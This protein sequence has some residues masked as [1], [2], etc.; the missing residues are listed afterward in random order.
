M[1]VISYNINGIRAAL[2]KGLDQWIQ[3][4]SPDILCL[5]EIKANESQF[6]IRIF[7]NLGY[8]SY[9][10][11]AQKAGYSGTAILS[12]KPPNRITCGMDHVQYDAEG[13]VLKADFDGF[14]IINVYM[15][16]GSSGDVRQTFKYQFLDDFYN[17]IAQ[18]LKIQPN[19]IVC[20]DYNICHKPI[21]IHNPQQN[22]HTSGF[23]PEE[24]QWLTKFLELGFVDT[25][26]FFCQEPHHYS[27]W[28]YRANARAKNLGWRIDYLL[29]STPLS[30]RLV[31]AQILPHAKHSD[32]CPVVVS[33]DV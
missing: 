23:L 19:L 9:W 27:W 15:P 18:Q 22:K 2:R 26:R 24:R 14:S 8:E 1:K 6:D 30:N 28:S 31:S 12:K 17:Y 7:Q 29:A 32:H 10:F 13:R 20:G 25:F 16:S 3:V 5:Q 21:D 33:F 4:S 11:P